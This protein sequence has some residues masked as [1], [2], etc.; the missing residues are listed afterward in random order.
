MLPLITKYT[1]GTLFL[2]LCLV[3]Q[4]QNTLK[5]TSPF[6]DEIFH[7]RQC[8]RY[9]H[10]NY[11]WDT[12]ITTPPGLYIL[13]VMFTRI[14]L[15]FT[16]KNVCD[17]DSW[18]RSIN[19]AG[20]LLVL[21]VIVRKFK[22]SSLWTVNI[23]SQ[24]LLFTYYFLFYTDIWSTILILGSLSLVWNSPTTKKCYMSSL[25]SFISLWFR[26]TNILWIA[27]ILSI[28]IDRQ[29][30]SDNFVS[31]CTKFII[32]FFK[33]W[34]KVIPFMIIFVLFIIFIKI[35][36]GIAFG[37]KENHQLNLHIVQVFYCFTF[38]TF[39]TWPVWLTRRTIENYVRFVF[40]KN[41][42]LNLIV[43]GGFMIVI[44]YIIDNFTI[45]HPF[46]LADNR[47]F[48]FYI[49]KKL[50]SHSYSQMF[51]IPLYHFSTWIIIT[52]LNKSKRG[53][54]SIT[55]ITYLFAVCL[56]I[57]PSPLFEPRYYIVPLIIFRLFVKSDRN[58]L[59]FLWLNSVNLFTSFVFFNYEFTWDS[60]PGVQR[61]I[62]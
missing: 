57:I 37:D 14:V 34:I 32:Q 2:I 30:R 12:K 29:I 61:I 62:W 27:F 60:E 11:E 44:K 53:L 46:L 6:I 54:S 13:G 28:I 43:N 26:Q 33:N 24:P 17:D 35:N 9:C 22:N 40:L 8:Q 15:I 21:P 52:T 7:L 58:L 55:I 51:A 3:I 5:L 4:N 16:T 48:T 18:L 49:F 47:H 38:I 1:A 31:R 19:L 39:F 20:G 42:G 36:G 50:I 41:Y 56:T 59:E 45:I 23:I 10:G 25:L